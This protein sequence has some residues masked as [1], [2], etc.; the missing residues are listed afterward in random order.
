MN[1]QIKVDTKGNKSCKCFKRCGGCQL[2]MPYE[3]QLEWKQSKAERMLSR[4]AE[5]KPIV[6]MDNPYNYR[7][8]VQTVLRLNQH[9]QIVSGVYQSS[10]KTMVTVED[11]M[12]EAVESQKIVAVIKKLMKSF[13]LLPFNERTGKGHIRHI[14]VRCA[15]ATGQIMVCIVTPSPIFPSKNNYAKA[16]KKECPEITTIVQNICDNPMPLTLGDRENILYGKGYIE[17]ILCGCRFRISSKSFY[18]VNHVQTEKLYSIAVSEAGLNRKDTL[19]DA[20]CGIGT[21]GIICASH[22][23]KVMGTELNKSACKDAVYNAKLNG[24]DNISFANCDAGM[25]MEDLAQK[26]EKADVVIMDPPRAGAD[27]RFLGSLSK[28]APSRVVYIS[29]KIETLERDLK[30]LKKL[31]YKA[32]SIQPVDMFPHTTGIETV[33]VLEKVN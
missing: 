15:E 1:T 28:L 19:I 2:D 3:Q 13:K 8:K 23:K 26:G 10:S 25:F 14:L 12:L 21:I 22:V 31:G 27:K 24:L 7:N 5:V 6:G 4:F 32:Q 29:C 9:K 11:C 17:D 33:V 30:V 20:Y 18:Q 16:L